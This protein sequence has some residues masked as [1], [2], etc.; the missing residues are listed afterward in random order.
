MTK[1]IYQLIPFITS[2][3]LKTQEST[4]NFALFWIATDEVI[5]AP[6]EQTNVTNNWVKQAKI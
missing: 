6:G 3:Y 5:V 4:H 1:K 2:S